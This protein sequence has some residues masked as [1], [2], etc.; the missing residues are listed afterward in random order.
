[1]L[2]VYL[3]ISGNFRIWQVKNIAA[4]HWRQARTSLVIQNLL[5]WIIFSIRSRSH[6]YSSV[7]TRLYSI[8]KGC[9]LCSVN[10]K[11]NKF[12]LLYSWSVS[13]FGISIRNMDHLLMRKQCAKEAEVEELHQKRILKHRRWN[14]IMYEYFKRSAPVR[15]QKI[16]RC[17][18]LTA[19]SLIK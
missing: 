16:E 9:N 12:K 2:P 19:K 1:M 14:L 11:D 7:V 13:E 10:D 6:S 18:V 3:S 4:C 15:Q 5:S 17:S 8:K